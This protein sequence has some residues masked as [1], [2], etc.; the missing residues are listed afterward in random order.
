MSVP[1]SVRKGRANLVIGL[2]AIGKSVDQIQKITGVTK[3][4][5]QNYAKEF[6]EGK[7]ESLESFKGKAF[8]SAAPLCRLVGFITA[9]HPRS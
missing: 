7:K 6:E 3:A 2:Y 9:L 5:I 1:L 4:T 8:S